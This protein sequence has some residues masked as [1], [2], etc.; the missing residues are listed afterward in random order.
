MNVA[1]AISLLAVSACSADKDDGDQPTLE[2]SFDYRVEYDTPNV[3]A[4]IARSVSFEDTSSGAPT[5]WS[6]SFPDGTSS[7][8]AS[9]TVSPAD[10][11]AFTAGE[12]T[13]TVRRGDETDT[14]T[15][16]VEIV[17]C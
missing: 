1:V 5:S 11:Q 9:P 10:A 15:D 2:A 3:T 13:L 4:C 12:V 16:R 8:D 14:V 17:A 6:W 7:E